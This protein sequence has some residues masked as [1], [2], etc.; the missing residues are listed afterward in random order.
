[1]QRYVL[2]EEWLH[3]LRSKGRKEDTIENYR[4]KCGKCLM[5]LEEYGRTTDPREI[6]SNDMVFLNGVL[7]ISEESRRDYLKV[8]NYWIKWCSGRDDVLD[9]ADILWNGTSAIHRVFINE[10]KFTKLM[11]VA[12]ERDR[13]ILL[14]GGAM[15]LRNSE[16][17]SVR[18]SD[19]KNG[20]LTIHGKGHGSEGKVAVMTIP[21]VVMQAIDEWT[22][23]RNGNG[24]EDLSGGCIIVSYQKAGMK[25]MSRSALS[26]HVR[27]LG[28]SA[29]ITVTV[30]SL[31][32]LFATSLY[33]HEVDL[34][35]IKTLMRHSNIHT[36]INCYIQ[37]CEER[38][39]DIMTN[40]IGEALNIENADCSSRHYEKRENSWIWGA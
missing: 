37:P 24:R 30:H 22:E 2:V 18:Y 3:Y 31:R 33:K 25:H 29:G 32:R 8:L 17:R 39:D 27:E 28:R 1:M 21:P 23:I 36:T 5:K 7:G 14:L 13:V 34:I 9:K 19:I 20:K 11:R 6:G 16:I 12:D 26:H 10:D 35:D 4:N 38:L 15:G 40:V